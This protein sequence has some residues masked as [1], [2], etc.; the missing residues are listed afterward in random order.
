MKGL[1]LIRLTNKTPCFISKGG[2]CMK[3]VP[4]SRLP[5]CYQP[6]GIV[7]HHPGKHAAMQFGIYRIYVRG[8]FPNNRIMVMFTI[9]FMCVMESKFPKIQKFQGGRGRR[10]RVRL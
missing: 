10:R 9:K 4:V 6:V 5:G 1:I 7:N 3:Q 2:P 8:L